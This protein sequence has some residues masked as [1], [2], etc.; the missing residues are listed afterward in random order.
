MRLL[1]MK[2]FL[3]LFCLHELRQLNVVPMDTEQLSNEALANAGLPNRSPWG[4]DIF[5]PSEPMAV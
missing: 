4:V 3:G 1:Q 5:A 2:P